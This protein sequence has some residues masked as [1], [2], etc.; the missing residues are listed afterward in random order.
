MACPTTSLHQRQLPPLDTSIEAI[1]QG[2]VASSQGLA[3]NVVLC[4]RLLPRG[5]F[6]SSIHVV[7]L[8]L[9]FQ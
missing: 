1:P 5:V 7:V 3:Q 9:H 2:R 8:G 6:L 4:V